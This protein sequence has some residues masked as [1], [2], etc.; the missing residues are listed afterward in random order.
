[1][2]AAIPVV[3]VSQDRN[4]TGIG[5]PYCK[6]NPLDPLHLSDVG[7]KLFVDAVVVALPKE[8]DVEI[9][10]GAGFKGVGIIDDVDMPIAD[11][12]QLV[13]SQILNLQHAFKEVG[14][15][16]GFHGHFPMFLWQ[17]HPGLLR[18]G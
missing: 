7:A 16:V 5:G 3:E 11:V 14:V 18:L 9:G 15:M 17:H 4:V 10:D 13:V 8:V 1:M 6:I 12:L 2:V